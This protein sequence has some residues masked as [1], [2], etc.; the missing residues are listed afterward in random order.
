VNGPNSKTTPSWITE[1]MVVHDI[2]LWGAADLRDFLT[3]E[4]AQQ[5]APMG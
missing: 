2:T 1:W 3:A 4:F 5:S